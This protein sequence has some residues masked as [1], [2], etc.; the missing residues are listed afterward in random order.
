MDENFIRR[1]AGLTTKPTKKKTRLIKRGKKLVRINP[2]KQENF[3]KTFDKYFPKKYHYAYNVAFKHLANKPK[4]EQIS[5][6]KR[7]LREYSRHVKNIQAAK[8]LEKLK[9]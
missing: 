3:K 4:H 6:L 2:N 1:F 8:I 7:V 9:I 5:E